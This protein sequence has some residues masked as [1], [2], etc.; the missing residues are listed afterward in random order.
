MKKESILILTL[1]TMGIAGC[2][3]KILTAQE[4]PKSNNPLTQD[5]NTP[6]QVPPFNTIKDEDY[7]P[8]IL[9]GIAEQEIEIKAI[10]DNKQTPTFENTIVALENS[11]KKL[12]KAT[13]VFYNLTSANTN[14]KLQ[15]LSSEIAPLLSNH[16]DNINLNLEL[17]KRVKTVY[18][19]REKANYSSI[20]AKLL[21]K[22]YKSFS[23]NGA[24]LSDAQ[25]ET[26]KQINSKLSLL[27]IKYG[28]NLLTETNSF[29]LKITDEKNLSGLPADLIAAAKETAD[30][31]NF[32]GWIFTLH[33]PSVMPFLQ[34]ADNRELRKTIFNAYQNRGNNNNEFDNN[35]IAL[36][37]INLRLEK[38]KLLGYTNY[39]AYVLEN[40]M[41]KTPEK[42]SELL[43]NLWTPAVA[44]AKAEA[45]DIADLMKK[46]KISGDVQPYDWRYYTEKIRLAKFN[47]NEQETKPYFSL[48]NVRQGI[49]TV[50]KNLYG[51]QFKQNKNIPTYHPDVTAWEVTEANGKEV[52][53]LYM[54]FYPRESKRGGAWMTSYRNQEMKD[55][56][57]VAPVISIVCN[58]TKPVGNTPALLTYDEV[59]T[60]F[61]EFGHA[62]HGLL[63]N[64]KY[65][66]LAGTNV[67]RDFVELPS[68]VM[69]NWATDSE[70]LKLYAKH[71]KTGEVIPD[72]LIKKLETAGTFDQG[73]QTV[74]YLAASILDM[75]YHTISKPLT[76]STVTFEKNAMDKLKLPSEIIPRYRSTYFSHIFS[77]GYAAGYYSYIWSGVLDTDAF[78]AFKSSGDVFNPAKAKLFRENVLEKGGTE[79]PM[80]LYKKFRGSEPKI[81][82]LLKKRGLN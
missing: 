64:V 67:P 71:Y 49:F 4:Q 81:N 13:T 78:D 54:D 56:Q 27:S 36:E 31:K 28:N 66:S 76:T 21:D 14:D 41:A 43:T 26:L 10:T 80:D 51:L 9:E 55:N 22:V 65:E 39:A 30:E 50:T 1:I 37:I 29:E 69:E 77:G 38:A 7:K 57:R 42:A 45:K 18:E 12:N 5:W 16:S 20:D 11:G 19:N 8:A 82:A 63:S 53:V 3:K 70:V 2:S 15:A 68:Q 75:D 23:R 79:E 6:H 48:E 17:Y 46:D 73:F 59:T 72:A 34:Y 25:K 35:K 61:H 62:L 32:N 33:N 52:G 60:F 47:L 58:F 44:K 24:N 40:S 74:E